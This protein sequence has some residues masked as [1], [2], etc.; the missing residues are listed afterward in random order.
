MEPVVYIELLP[1][2]SAHTK[3]SQDKKMITG[4]LM[5]LDQ[6]GDTEVANSSLLTH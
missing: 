5:Y 2:H 4:K 1:E 3:Y 6:I